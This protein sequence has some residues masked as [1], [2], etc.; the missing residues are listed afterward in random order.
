MTVCQVRAAADALLD[1]LP[2]NRE[3]Q[4][5]RLDKAARVIRWAQARNAASKASHAK[6]RSRA[7]LAAR[8]RIESLRC[9]IPP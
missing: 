5:L 8:I 7:L 4:R 1:A 3:D 9:C 2:L 6:A